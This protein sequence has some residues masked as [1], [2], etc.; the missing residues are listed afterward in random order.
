MDLR[1]FAEEILDLCDEV[2][3]LRRENARLR[4]VEEK[5]QEFVHESVK[6][7]EAQMAGWMDLLMSGKLKIQA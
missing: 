7:G 6:S 4:I 1:A 5:H 3:E 2:D